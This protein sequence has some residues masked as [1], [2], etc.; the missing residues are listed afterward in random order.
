M[1]ASNRV[2][3]F[4]IAPTIA[5]KIDDVDFDQNQIDFDYHVEQISLECVVILSSIASKCQEVTCY[6]YI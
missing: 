1:G 4:K 3:K 6:N 2:F 5:N